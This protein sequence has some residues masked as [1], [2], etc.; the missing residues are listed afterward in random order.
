VFPSRLRP[1]RPYN[2]DPAWQAALSAAGVKNF[3]LHD[4][5]HSCASA[6]AQSGATLV[7]I[8]AILG[9][10]QLSVTLRYSHLNTGHKSALVNRVLGA[11]R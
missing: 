4:L 9:H 8:A 11:F 7:E 6:L 3:R 5:R 10:R 2:F 1:D